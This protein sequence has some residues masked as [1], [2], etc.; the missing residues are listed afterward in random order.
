MF[1]V[2]LKQ[3]NLSNIV[4]VYGLYITNRIQLNYYFNKQDTIF[5]IIECVNLIFIYV[6]YLQFWSKAS[7][8]SIAMSLIS[9][10]SINSLGIK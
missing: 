9:L 8:K 7:F 3:L 1:D 4:E 10:P 5:N 2:L 6:Y